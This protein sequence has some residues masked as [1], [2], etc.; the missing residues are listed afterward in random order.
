MP[1]E[2]P[3]LSVNFPTQELFN[4]VLRDASFNERSDSGQVVWILKQYYA[5][6]LKE[7]EAFTPTEL[8]ESERRKVPVFETK[9]PQLSEL[10][11]K[12]RESRN[13]DQS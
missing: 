9:H 5:A 3:R 8:S 10:P 2:L 11:S 6:K 7:V 13:Q 12:P 1:T 4:M